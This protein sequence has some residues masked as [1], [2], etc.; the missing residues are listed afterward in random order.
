MSWQQACDLLFPIPQMDPREKRDQIE[1]WAHKE[2]ETNPTTARGNGSKEIHHSQDVG[3][4]SGPADVAAL[5]SFGLQGH[6]LEPH[7]QSLFGKHCT[8]YQWVASSEKSAS[9]KGGS[10]G[11]EVCK[12][13]CFLHLQKWKI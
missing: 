11:T 7:V 13:I 1:H 12:N 10:S 6:G 3:L 5:L 8:G 2:P 9:G 4:L